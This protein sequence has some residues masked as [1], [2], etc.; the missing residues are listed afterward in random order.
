MPFSHSESKGE[1]VRTVVLVCRANLR[2]WLAGALWY[3]CV[4]EGCSV[5]V[6]RTME[7]CGS[8][9]TGR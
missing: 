8:V 1:W 2:L 7:P 6:R 9:G 3:D 4:V 5:P